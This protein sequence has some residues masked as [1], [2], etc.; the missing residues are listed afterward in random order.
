VVEDNV[1][2]VA[3]CASFLLSLDGE[4][5]A[6]EMRRDDTRGCSRG[7]HHD[8]KERIECACG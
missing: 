7:H 8:H 4:Q 2:F 1:F 3:S 6:P 5:L